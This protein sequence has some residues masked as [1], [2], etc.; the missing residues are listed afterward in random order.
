MDELDIRNGSCSEWY[1][2]ADHEASYVFDPGTI[3]EKIGGGPGGGWTPVVTDTTHLGLPASTDIDAFEF[4]WLWDQNENRNGLAL[5]FSVDD[6]DP[7]TPDD[8]SGGLDSRIIYYSFLNGSSQVFLDGFTDD[9]DGIAIWNTPLFAGY[10]P[11]QQPCLP[12]TDLVIT[13]GA[14]M[15]NLFFTAPQSTNYT[16]YSSG[17]PDNNLP[18]DPSWVSEVDIPAVAGQ[19]VTAT[20]PMPTLFRKYVVI[21]QCP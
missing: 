2:S 6:D 5:L 16:V 10:A 12:V 3:Y 21:A 9:I 17:T 20:L 18:P 19:Q 15:V 4:C 8:E 7:Q 11:P 14:G 1:F 13:T